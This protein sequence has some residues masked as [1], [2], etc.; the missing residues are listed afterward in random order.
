VQTGKLGVSFLLPETQSACAAGEAVDLS[1]KS[2]VPLLA[3]ESGKRCP[4]C[5]ACH[6][7]ALLVLTFWRRVGH[8]QHE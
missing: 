4:H 3:E 7:W 5:C 2:P 1:D 6:W 8:W